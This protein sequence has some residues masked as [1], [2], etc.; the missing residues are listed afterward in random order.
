MP[1]QKNRS[2]LTGLDQVIENN[3]EEM[4]LISLTSKVIPPEDIK[5]NILTLP[6]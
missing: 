2:I 4:G 5:E 6:T 3:N 1:A